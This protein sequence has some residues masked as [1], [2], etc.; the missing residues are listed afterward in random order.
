MNISNGAHKE[1]LN[2]LPTKDKPNKFE[3]R[4][5]NNIL[6]TFRR[7]QRQHIMTSRF[8]NKTWHENQQYRQKKQICVY[9]APIPVTQQVPSDTILF[10]L[11]MNNDTN[12]IM[13]IGLIK[14]HPLCNKH[15]VY[16]NGNYNRYV[17]TSRHHISR[18]AMTE[19]EETI[20]KALDILCF[21]GNRHMK[22]GQGLTAFPVDM[23]YRCRHIV[24]LVQ[25][26]KNMFAMREPKTN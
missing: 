6:K 5:E 23:L 13:G 1:G 22:R 20:L 2:A 8:N 9:C 12:Q 24:D 26:I 19:K 17:Y 25:F 4:A 7:E 16:D 14:N 21:K 11:E 10:V 15:T 18:D 3:K